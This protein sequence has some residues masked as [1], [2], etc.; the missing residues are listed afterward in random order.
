MFKKMVNQKCYNP[1][2][3]LVGGEGGALGVEVPPP[4][5]YYMGKVESFRSC[6][7]GLVAFL[8]MYWKKNIEREE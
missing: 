3:D 2:A 5:F 8:R 4:K 7:T 1:E 6:S